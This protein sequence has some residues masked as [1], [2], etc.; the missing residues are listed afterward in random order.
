MM[1]D[2]IQSVNK[3]QNEFSANT[4]LSSKMDD[5]EKMQK[6]VDE[7]NKK[8]KDA[9]EQIS[10]K[11]DEIQNSID[12]AFNE[13][14]KIPPKIRSIVDV[15]GAK[16]NLYAKLND[17]QK[18]GQSFIEK[19]MISSVVPIEK[20]D[21][22]SNPSEYPNIQSL[23]Y[24]YNTVTDE[25]CKTSGY[26]K[27]KWELKP[28]FIEKF[29]EMV[30]AKPENQYD[31]QKQVSKSMNSVISG[32]KPLIQSV[33]TIGNAVPLGPIGDM[34][35]TLSESLNSVAEIMS[36]KLDEESLNSKIAQE[37]VGTGIID[38]MT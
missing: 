28:E 16:N 10:K 9:Q 27:V 21:F 26:T 38:S 3:E 2:D 8:I 30:N 34:V 36:M 25:M 32:F 29:K 24:L 14:R 18:S 1:N 5:I 23:Q 17:L 33:N 15:E 22:Y 13:F 6:S 31:V 4:S 7:A 19:N 11:M 35:N 20:E 12:N 37:N